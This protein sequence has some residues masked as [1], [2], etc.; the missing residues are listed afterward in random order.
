VKI[1][2]S[3]SWVRVRGFSRARDELSDG[4]KWRVIGAT[5]HSSIGR[6]EYGGARLARTWWDEATRYE[7]ITQYVHRAGL[8]EWAAIDDH[9]EAWAPEH[10][11]KLILTESELGLSDPNTAATLMDRLGPSWTA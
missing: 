5:W 11:D 6:S 2:L 7:Q 8:V 1:V 10:R 4:I 3:T 9:G